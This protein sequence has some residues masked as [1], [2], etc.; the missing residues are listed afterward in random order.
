[1]SDEPANA[2]REF[3]GRLMDMKTF[4]TQDFASF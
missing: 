2:S 4:A 3:T 1:M